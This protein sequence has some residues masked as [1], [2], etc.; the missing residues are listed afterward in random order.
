MSEA[1]KFVVA[2][3]GE[4]LDVFLTA[5][6][7]DLSRSRIRRLVEDGSVTVDG[8]CS[9]ASFRLSTG[10][11]VRL[12]I[13]PPSQPRLRPSR[14]P[15]NIIFEDGHL[16]VI[17][18]AAGMAVHPGPGNEDDTLANAVLA[19]APGLVGI[20]W[21]GRP[22]IVHRLDKDTSGLIV[23]A[24]TDLAHASLSEQFKSRS[25]TKI[26][27]ALVAGQPNPQEA[28]IDAP[29]GRHPHDRQRMAV[30][31]TGRPARTRYRVL[32]PYSHTSF[33]EARPKTGRTH[34]IRV[35]MASIGHPVVGDAAYGRPAPGL[36]RQF[37]H[38]HEIA[39]R[40]PDSSESL[41][42]TSDLPDDLRAHLDS[43]TAVR[44]GERS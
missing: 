32:T 29:I 18:K 19:H 4:R 11:T 13:P 6:R 1:A 16:M 31:S 2:E 12:E 15:L 42:F 14:I 34:Q 10:Q 17:D 44:P 28:D 30:V 24:K 8:R 37:L 26:Y 22:G 5:R 25:V 38:A 9:K 41:R 23:A 21:S 35:H 43:L 20:G 7:S 3:G 27:L 36:R 39:F 33:I 40:H